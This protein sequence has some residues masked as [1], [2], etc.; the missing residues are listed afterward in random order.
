MSSTLRLPWLVIVT[1]SFV[2]ACADGADAPAA[3]STS[4]QSFNIDFKTDPS[5]PQSGENTV[6][7]T[8][9]NANGSALNDANVEAIFYMPAM[10]SMNMPEMR[11]VFSLKNEGNGRY[12]GAGR[13]VMNGTW[14]VTVNVTRGGD[15]LGSKRMTIV[16]K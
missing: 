4:S 3:A 11:S 6:E 1:A 13:L 10:P 7:V 12:R 15:K 9:T 2:M 8:I 5:P 14:E 16:A